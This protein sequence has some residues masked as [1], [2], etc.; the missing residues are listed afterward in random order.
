MTEDIPWPWEMMEGTGGAGGEVMNCLVGPVTGRLFT[1][2]GLR[3][4]DVTATNGRPAL[5][6]TSVSRPT[7]GLYIDRVSVV[8]SHVCWLVSQNDALGLSER[9]L[10][11]PAG[12]DVQRYFSSKLGRRSTLEPEDRNVTQHR[13]MTILHD[14]L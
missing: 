6:N 13:D 12:L 9:L 8:M 10:T 14:T 1:T 5:D 7:T 2:A 11:D 4:R 3:V